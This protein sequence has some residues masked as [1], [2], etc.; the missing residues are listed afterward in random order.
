MR[1]P[2]APAALTGMSGDRGS[3]SQDPWKRQLA[4][5]R[6]VHSSFVTASYGFP[7]DPSEDGSCRKFVITSLLVIA[8]AIPLSQNFHGM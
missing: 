1:S 8:V 3:L 7:G 6:D 4:Q 5:T 2:P